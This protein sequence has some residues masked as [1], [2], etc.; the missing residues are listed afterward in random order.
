MCLCGSTGATGSLAFGGPAI[1]GPARVDVMFVYN[2]GLLSVGNASVVRMVAQVMVNQANACMANSGV[3]VSFRIVGFEQVAYQQADPR[4]VTQADLDALSTGPAF[5]AA[6]ARRAQLGADLYCLMLNLNV[7]FGSQF[8]GG[9][10]TIANRLEPSQGYSVVAY[11]AL[12]ANIFAHEVGHNFGCQHESG[13][14]LYPFAH[15]FRKPGRWATVMAYPQA[16]EL[17]IPYF[18]SPAVTFQG[19]ATG[20]A[21]V[22]DEARALRLSGPVIAGYAAATVPVASPTP[23][24]AP[25]PL[26]VELSAGWN[27]V[28]FARQR[29]SLVNPAVVVGTARFVGGE[30]VTDGVSVIDTRQGLWVY[31]SAQATLLYTGAEDPQGNFLRLREGWSFVNFTSVPTGVALPLLIEPLTGATV[32]SPVAGHAYWAYSLRDELLTWP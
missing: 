31:A 16:G 1:A 27:P 6:R 22:A 30:Y 12:S 23:A 17:R 28:G 21:E 3:D 29:V 26:A 7:D 4:N 19:D 9:I 15:G 25:S 32:A 24:V 5:A 2:Q 14:A 10:A 18:S 20:L 8:V 11:N 13:E